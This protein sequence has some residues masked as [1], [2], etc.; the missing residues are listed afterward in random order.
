MTKEESAA[1]LDMSVRTLQRLTAAGLF[2]P[3]TTGAKGVA[4]YDRAE[5]DSWKELSDDERKR[6]RAE[7]QSQPPAALVTTRNFV[8]TRHP[9]ENALES[10]Q[11]LTPLP[12]YLSRIASALENREAPE[13]LTPEEVAERL[14]LKTRT[15]LRLVREGKLSA[16]RIGRLYRFRPADLRSFIEG[17]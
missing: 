3:V 7:A 16:V 8:T 11:I 17:L 4:V 1:Y 9:A 13:L 2:H 15:V 5:L 6:L 14:K 10:L 12:D